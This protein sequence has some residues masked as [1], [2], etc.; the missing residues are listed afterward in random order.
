MNLTRRLSILCILLSTAALAVGFGAGGVRR[1]ALWIIAGGLVWLA[2]RRLKW[3]WIHP[4]ALVF[5]AGAAGL[6][7][8]LGFPAGW[9]LAGLAGALSAWDLEYFARRVKS[10]GEGAADRRLERQHLERLGAVIGTGVVLAGA[11]LLAR[12]RFSFGVGLLAGLLAVLALSQVIGFIR[13]E[14]D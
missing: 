7:V 8:L 14:S 13:R 4:L 12:A 9:M 2:A 11:S 6:G 10:V 5:Y 3:G 1:A